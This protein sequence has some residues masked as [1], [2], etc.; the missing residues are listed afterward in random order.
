MNENLNIK[1]IKM[2]DVKV[3]IIC[4]V[5][6]VCI[7]S[8]NMIVNNVV[9]SRN[10]SEK[11]SQVQELT[12]QIEKNRV[13]ANQSLND[14][15]AK[16]SGLDTNRVRTDD[17]IVDAFFKKIFT[18]SSADEYNAVRDELLQSDM[19]A[20]DNSLLTILFPELQEGQDASGDSSNIIDDGVYGQLNMTYDSMT[21]H[22]IGIDGTTYSY[23][24]EI[25]VLSQVAGGTANSG[26]IVVTYS[27]DKDGQIL[28]LSAYT[29]AE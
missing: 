7:L 16:V 14:T 19:L 27:V 26:E 17:G 29:V 18:W 8:G 1:N 25:T 5:V 13:L 10:L 2:K 23:F 12:A 22:V 24:T 3:L 15:K 11:S 6:T 4:I 20:A 9:Y 28:D 21:S